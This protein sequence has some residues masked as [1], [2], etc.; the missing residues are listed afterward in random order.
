VGPLGIRC[1][2]LVPGFFPAEQNREILTPE[3][4]EKIVGHTPLA[5]FGEVD[6][7]AGAILLL[8]GDAGRFITGAELVVDGG[9]SAMTI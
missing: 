3:R 6:E 2:V 9:F 1:N 8:A 7:L 5:R 4:I